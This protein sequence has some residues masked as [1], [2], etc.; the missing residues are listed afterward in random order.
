LV[1]PADVSKAEQ[2]ALYLTSPLLGIPA[3]MRRTLSWDRSR[4]MVEHKGYLSR[5]EDGGLAM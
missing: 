1:A 4:E 5:H 2:V 3:R